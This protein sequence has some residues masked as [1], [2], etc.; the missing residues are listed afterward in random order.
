MIRGREN[1]AC[2][3]QIAH[4]VPGD[5]VGVARDT[6]AEGVVHARDMVDA[7][8]R[9]THNA[10]YLGT[11]EN[12]RAWLDANGKEGD[13]VVTVGSGDVYKQTKKLL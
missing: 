4:P 8:N 7:I 6:E 13:L 5:A 10:L 2:R 1:D 9:T 3:L 11:F 12:I